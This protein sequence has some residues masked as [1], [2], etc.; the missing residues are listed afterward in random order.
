MKPDGTAAKKSKTEVMFYPAAGY[1]PTD[2]D[3]LPLRVDDHHCI[4]TFTDQFRY[5]GAVISSSLTDDAEITNRIRSA[6]AAFG[7]LQRWV[8][9][10]SFGSKSL[11]LASKGKLYC[12]LVLCI[13]LYGCESWVLTQ[14]L[15]QRLHTFHNCCVRSMSGRAARVRDGEHT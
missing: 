8:F 6:A 14:P 7:S 1:T 11:P 9:G 3:T 13:L 2:N 12:S 15:L 5:L 10:Q 4:V